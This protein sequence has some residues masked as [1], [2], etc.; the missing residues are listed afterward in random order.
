M[1]LKECILLAA[2]ALNLD[3]A[4]DEQLT[5]TEK[6]LIRCANNCLDEITS[7][8]IPL[9]CE[10]TVQS[11]NGSIPYSLISDTVYDVISVTDINGARVRF[12][13]MPSRIK[14]DKDGAYKVIYCT[15]APTLQ[16]EDD[17]PI[18]LHLTPRII[19]Y[20]IAA[21]YLLVTGFYEEAVTYDTRFKDALKRAL[22][23]HGEKRLKGRRWLI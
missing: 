10:L 19:S 20:G 2:S 11:S 14:V 7:E 5:D 1:K 6:L 16:L 15:R 12:S 17:V 22:S 18:E 21:E 23:G 9:K 13:L 3:V 8:Y 4:F